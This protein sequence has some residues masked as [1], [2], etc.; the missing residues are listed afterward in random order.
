MAKK[1]NKKE[2]YKLL[3]GT[4]P[5]GAQYQFTASKIADV[6]GVS[7]QYVHQLIKEFQEKNLIKCV[8]PKDYIRF[9]SAT[10]KTF[11]IKKSR[12][13]TLKEYNWTQ[14]QK[15]MIYGE[16]LG[17]GYLTKKYH[18]GL[19]TTSKEHTIFLKNNLPIDLFSNCTPYTYVP[20]NKNWKTSYQLKSRLCK[21]F[22]FMRYK[23][24][25]LG[26]KIIPLDI[27]LNPIT[28]Y[29]WYIGDGY[30]NKRT[31]YITLSTDCFIKEDIDRLVSQLIENGINAK[32]VKA[33]RRASAILIKKAHE[34]LEW[35]GKNEIKDY[36]YKWGL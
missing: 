7:R 1:A 4:H 21:F 15:S 2:V 10:E 32:R 23:W 30:F 20:Q 29:H 9:Y 13:E 25:P 31:S 14:K 33:G 27:V 3:I 26:I 5:S 18:F 11:N 36:N 6:Q 34:F 16:L 12:L 17:D 22:Y 19:T 24:Y 8:N 28:C 35:I